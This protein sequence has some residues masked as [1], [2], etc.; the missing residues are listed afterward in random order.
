MSKSRL[1]FGPCALDKYKVKNGTELAKKDF[2]EWLNQEINEQM[3]WSTKQSVETLFAALDKV[4]EFNVK[5]EL[6]KKTNEIELRDAGHELECGLLKL[7][8]YV[9]TVLESGKPV[10]TKTIRL[11]VKAYVLEDGMS[12]KCRHPTLSS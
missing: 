11:A 4:E 7:D 8:M 3:P 1:E 5:S 6:C 9:P 12:A 10:T 2:L